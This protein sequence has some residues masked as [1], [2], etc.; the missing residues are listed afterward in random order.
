MP[1]EAGH[2]QPVLT[3]VRVSVTPISRGNGRPEPGLRRTTSPFRTRLKRIASLDAWAVQL[4][5]FPSRSRS[6]TSTSKQPL[7]AADPDWEGDPAISPD[8]RYVAHL[9]W[10][11]AFRGQ[12]QVRPF[13]AVEDAL[14]EIPGAI[15]EDPLWSRDGRELYYWTQDTGLMMAVPVATEP[16]FSHGVARELFPFNFQGGAGRSYDAAPDGRFLLVKLA[17][18]GGAA[19][20]NMIRNWTA[21]LKARVPTE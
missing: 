8:G 1:V 4:L 5:A 9:F 20:I 6:V 3:S 16:E 2:G 7:L 12:V 13:P 11:E 21:E 14:W 15:G 17:S 10:E 18:S 19:H